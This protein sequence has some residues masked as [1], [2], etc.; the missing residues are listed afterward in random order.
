MKY[1]KNITEW[2]IL[3]LILT[4]QI[5]LTFQGLDLA[6]TGFHLSAFHFIFNDPYSVQYSMMFWLSD[7]C[8]ALW[9]KL[10]PAGGLYWMRIGWVFVSSSTFLVFYH[11]LR[12]VAD[13]K[14]AL[15]SLSITT[16]FILRGGPEC[17]NYDLFTALGY[18]LSLLFMV[19]GLLTPKAYLLYL[20]GL[21]LGISF[22]FKLSNISSLGFLLLIPFFGI[23]SH[24]ERATILKNIGITIAGIIT[25]ATLIL[26]LI[27]ELGH[28][29]LFWEN[30]R[31]IVY[32][33]ADQQASHGLKPML[34]S[35]LYGY[36]NAFVMLTV[37]LIAVVILN[38]FHQRHPRLL[39]GPNSN[40]LL[41]IMASILLLFLIF[42]P[43]PVW[44]KIRYLFIGLML[45]YGIYEMLNL[46]TNK[47]IRLLA[48]AGLLLLVI[49]PLGS[50]SGLGKS[51][52]GM[53]LLGPLLLI[54][55]PSFNKLKIQPPTKELVD[56][57]RKAVAILLLV[58]GIVY[59]WQHTYF[60][61]G[62]RF[63][64]TYS[65]RHP[66][67]KLIYTSP[68]RAN[69]MN[70]L[71]KDGLPKLKDQ[72][73]L[74]SFIEI[75][76]F[77]YLTDKQPFIS[78]SWPK[79]YYKPQT[80]RDKLAEALIHRKQLPAIIRQTQATK[81]ADWPSDGPGHFDDWPGHLR[82]LDEFTSQYHYQVVWEN[83]IFQVLICEE[84]GK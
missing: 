4:W 35:Y 48:F 70:E 13:R 49:T 7:V 74:L 32:M 80:F 20:S 58:S 52:W 66:K 61:T 55:T 38:K 11:L 63:Q 42:L 34:L 33:G 53:W 12:L 73:Y 83:E 47:T 22:F 57:L 46:N 31:F 6:D 75:P 8:G 25:G 23:I 24:T 45:Y 68:A 28:W 3:F 41:V 77:N 62:S 81:L 67:L 76:L 15:I 84:N 60:D 37:F 50:D 69:A 54:G 43:D 2:Q 9:M 71:I 26:L 14:P 44:S 5:L 30:I 18:S 40:R 56:V 39:Q 1:F 10:F 65:I 17:L 29:Q 59:A 16:V 79:L 78:T 27:K 51:I 21:L 19:R 82:V 64:K 72:S 36:A